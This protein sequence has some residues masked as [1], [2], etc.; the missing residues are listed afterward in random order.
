MIEVLF[1]SAFSCLFAEFSGIMLWVKWKLNLKRFK[2]FDCAMCLSWWLGIVYFGISTQNAILT[3]G[4]AAL[5]S[6]LSIYITKYA[7]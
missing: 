5:C 6:V 7:K 4:C 2:P 1:I 3:V